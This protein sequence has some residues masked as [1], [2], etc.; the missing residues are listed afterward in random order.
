MAVQI[1]YRSPVLTSQFLQRLDAAMQ[2]APIAQVLFDKKRGWNAQFLHHAKR[3]GEVCRDAGI[4]DHQQPHL[5]RASQNALVLA[6]MLRDG[7]QTQK[8]ASSR[9]FSDASAIFVLHT[10]DLGYG[11][12][13]A[14]VEAYE[15]VNHEEES[16]RIVEEL[17][18][19]VHRLHPSRR[20]GWKYR[21][22]YREAI[23][24]TL[25]D[26]TGMMHNLLA[27]Q[28]SPDTHT[29]FQL[30]IATA[31]KADYF[32]SHRIGELPSPQAYTDNPYYF[33][34]DAVEAYRLQYDSNRGVLQYAVALHQNKGHQTT[35]GE[36][37]SDFSVWKEATQEA[38][39]TVF[40][41]LRGIAALAGKDFEIVKLQEAKGGEGGI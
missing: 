14:Q 4:C 26:P 21:D 12:D 11:S 16:A 36:L 18:L 9:L 1:E 22:V 3:G 39:P 33:L 23:L 31:D 25:D 17:F 19:G 29:L 41:L 2:Q 15:V 32:I 35:A 6:D 27:A 40:A 20:M 7:Q 24:G 34:A 13:N 10:H 37:L 30:M 38:Y 28:T 5:L 8:Q